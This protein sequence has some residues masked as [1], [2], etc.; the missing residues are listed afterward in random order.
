MV[1]V[2]RGRTILAEPIDDLRRRSRQVRKLRIRLLNG[3]LDSLRAA[4]ISQS[5][6]T[7]AT[8]DDDALV[9]EVE[10]GHRAQ[11]VEFAQQHGGL[12]E[13]FEERR[14][15][16]EVFRDLVAGAAQSA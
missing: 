1:V 4:V 7:N 15:L 13:L 10:D 16:E 3:A 6:V 2:D 14:S 8:I 5:W 12:S 9:L 11:L